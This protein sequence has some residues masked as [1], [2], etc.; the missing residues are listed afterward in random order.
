[1]RLRIGDIRSWSADRYMVGTGI[2]LLFRWGGDHLSWMLVYEEKIKVINLS[3][4]E[5]ILVAK[6]EME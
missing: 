3:C 6:Q 1:M 4:C 5:Y 2:C